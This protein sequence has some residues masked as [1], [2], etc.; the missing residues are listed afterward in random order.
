MVC[1]ARGYLEGKME[2]WHTLSNN[3]YWFKN[4]GQSELGSMFPIGKKKTKKQRNPYIHIYLFL[5]LISSPSSSTTT[6]IFTID[7][8][9]SL[10]TCRTEQLPMTTRLEFCCRTVEDAT[11]QRRVSL[12]S[13]GGFGSF[14][15]ISGD[16]FSQLHHFWTKRS[17]TNPSTP[18]IPDE[19]QLFRRGSTVNMWLSGQME[20]ICEV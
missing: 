16:F 13:R 20:V 14:L 4:M 2:N 17:K 5:S 3:L 15:A 18:I 6:S 9:V 19:S 8:T 1:D 10:Y 7:Q 12:S 11:C